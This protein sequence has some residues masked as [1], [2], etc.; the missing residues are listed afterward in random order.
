MT[1]VQ[2]VPS[3]TR[4]AGS[5][6]DTR[7]DLLGFVV[8]FALPDVRIVAG[9]L[10]S[11]AMSAGL[12]DTPA[13]GCKAD[14]FRRATAPRSR[15]GESRL[16]RYMMRPVCDTGR[17]LVRHLVVERVD[18]NNVSLGHVAVAEAKFNHDTEQMS[19]DGL[20]A[21]RTLTADEQQTVED[22][23][24]EADANYAEFTTSLTGAEIQRWV[25]KQLE[26]MSHV[27]VHPRGAVYFIPQQR[28]GVLRQVQSL[29]NALKSYAKDPE[30]QPVFTIVP[31]LDDPEQRETV[32]AGLA[33]G[34][35]SELHTLTG[36]IAELLN[37]P[38]KPDSETAAF[39]VEQIS[40]MLRK[41]A[42]YEK[43]LGGTMDDIRSSVE[44]VKLQADEL[45][46][47]A[48]AATDPLI[49]AAKAAGCLVEFSDSKRSA[50]LS[51]KLNPSREISVRFNDS[52]WTVIG[53]VKNA[54]IA[55]ELMD[56]DEFTGHDR[57][58]TVKTADADVAMLY[59]RSALRLK[60]K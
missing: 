46:D 22:L 3:I 47:R 37:R 8:W 33:C 59:I 6:S 43:L 12:T 49:D 18:P 23:V 2:T 42:E 31:V 17:E 39:K 20:P 19:F 57:K 45:I 53:G 14:A 35:E 50:T 29:V 27:S 24:Q 32:K 44:I 26:K 7:T 36:E 51:S 1:T 54:A 10:A 58:W 30:N 55:A 48:S 56:R 21:V 25:M 41:V 11:L 28:G 60:S 16:T 52:G 15:R 40:A 5:V 13:M 9:Q 34:V 38:S 4:L